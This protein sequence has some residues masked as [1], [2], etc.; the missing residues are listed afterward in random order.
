MD[1][2]PPA[3]SVCGIIPARILEWVAIPFSRGSSQPRDEP[4]S[5]TLLADSLSA[6]PQGKPRN[7]GMGSLSF[8]QQIFPVQELNWGLMHCRQI[9][10]QLSYQEALLYSSVIEFFFFFLIYIDFNWRLITL[11]YCI[12]FAIHQHE[13]ATGVHVFPIL[14]PPPTSLPV[15]S[16]WVIPVHQP[17]VSCILH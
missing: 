13:S 4:R 9:L 3:S 16:L 7:T 12:G 10:Y 14:S 6:E 8:P 15:P 2:S 5:P 1:C 17:Q 11:Q